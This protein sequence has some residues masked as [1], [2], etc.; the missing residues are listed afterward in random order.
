MFE[1]TPKAGNSLNDIDIENDAGGNQ[2]ESDISKTAVM[3]FGTR[4]KERLD[5]EEEEGQGG[6]VERIRTSKSWRDLGPPPDGGVL[7]WTQG[8]FFPFVV[9]VMC[10]KGIV[11]FRLARGR[12]CLLCLFVNDGIG[13][14]KVMVE[15]VGLPE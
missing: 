8:L 5:R 13:W 14:E 9:L 15:A 4:E 7:A 1:E 10:W 6:M 12:V 2:S 3:D 11:F